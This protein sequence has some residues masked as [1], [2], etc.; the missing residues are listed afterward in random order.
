[1]H[2]ELKEAAKICCKDCK[3]HPCNGLYNCKILFDHIAQKKI[4][5][6][7]EFDLKHCPFCK[8]DA[9][10]IVAANGIS[11]VKCMNGCVKTKNFSNPEEAIKHWNTRF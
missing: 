1:M 11:N 5:E 3:I 4:D 9:K 8:A 2:E 6:L 10:L 7:G